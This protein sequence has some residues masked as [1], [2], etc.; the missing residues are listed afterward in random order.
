MQIER[1]S[2]SSLVLDPANARKHDKKN[3]EAIKGSL[4][5]FG[6]QKPIVVDEKGVVIAG[7]GTLVAARELGW[8]D[9]D[10]HR[11]V[12]KGAEAMAFALAD[13]KTAELALWDEDVLS[14]QLSAL[15]KDGWDIEA[16]GFEAEQAGGQGGTEGNTDPDE[17]PE[18]EQNVHKVERGQ[19]WQLGDHRMMCGDSTS[20]D[21][22]AK[23]MGG[24]KADMVFTDPPYNLGSHTKCVGADKNKAVK[25]L[26]ENNWDSNFDIKPALINIGDY[27]SASAPFYIFTSQFL[28]PDIWAWMAERCEFYSYIV[29]CKP[30]PMPLLIKK[31]WNFS[32][33]ELVCYGHGKK[34]TFP[35]LRL[36]T[37]RLRENRT[38]MLRDGNRPSLLQRD[39]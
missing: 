13:N 28:A 22:V 10:I 31:T 33:T 36:N 20:K 19:I 12:L 3:L 32:S 21:D 6:Q 14:S 25:N 39:N 7:N 29:W 8:E 2:V 23:L 4:S 27:S 11:S 24:E 17:I 5:K 26:S 16:I 37:N 1:V 35:R 30:N 15:Y 9:I 38:Q 34:L 18:V